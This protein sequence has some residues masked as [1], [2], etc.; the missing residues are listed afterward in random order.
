MNFRDLMKMIPFA[1]D[2]DIRR[3]EK[4]I[5]YYDGLNFINPEFMECEV[6]GYGFDSDK[7]LVWVDVK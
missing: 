2:I 3:D 4:L 7:N 6:I 1:M 5:G